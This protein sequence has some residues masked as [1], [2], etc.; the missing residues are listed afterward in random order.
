MTSKNTFKCLILFSFYFVAPFALSAQNANETPE[1]VSLATD[2]ADRKAILKTIENFYIG[3]H[4]GS[5]KHKKLSM[6]EKGAYRY[7]NKDGEYREST[8]QL[9]SDNA[10]PNYKEELL[11]IEIYEKVALARLRLHQ[12]RMEKPEY[13][14]MILH[15][16]GD[17]WKI[18]SISWGFGITY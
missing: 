11:S 18:T 8:F 13:K 10:D 14:L 5:I 12:F 3:D 16:A 17:A 6:H 2:F 7:V 9:D 4:T 15:K 1:K